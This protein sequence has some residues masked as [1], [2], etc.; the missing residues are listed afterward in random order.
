[1]RHH[2]LLTVGR[3][4]GEAFYLAYELNQ[5]CDIQLAAMAAGRELLEF[6]GEESEHWAQKHHGSDIYSY[7]GGKEWQGWMRMLEREDQSYR[8]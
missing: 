6:S 4:L 7:D 5:A 3:T 1:M 2:G 8:S